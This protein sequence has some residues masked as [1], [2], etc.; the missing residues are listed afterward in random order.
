MRRECIAIAGRSPSSPMRLRKKSRTP[1]WP[2]GSLHEA[3]HSVN[4]SVSQW[5]AVGGNG[6]SFRGNPHERISHFASCNGQGVSVEEQDRHRKF[7]K[8]TISA[9]VADLLSNDI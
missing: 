9:A 3:I 6:L 5:M 4:V 1:D 2:R 7:T 8:L